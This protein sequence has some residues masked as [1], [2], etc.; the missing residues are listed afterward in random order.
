LTQK[1]WPHA[2]LPLDACRVS[3]RVAVGEGAV[4]PPFRNHNEI[5]PVLQQMLHALPS[6]PGADL[7]FVGPDT[8]T[9]YDALFNP[10][11]AE[12]NPICHLLALLG[13]ATIVVVS[14]L[15]NTKLR[16]QS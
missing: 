9:I 8:Y 16:K 7:R 4:T 1:L 15:R 2:G 13:G 11:N 6:P 10:L 5:A 12:L 14:R 3:E